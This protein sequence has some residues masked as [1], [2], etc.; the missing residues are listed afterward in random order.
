[1]AAAAASGINSSS[2]DN[3]GRDAVSPSSFRKT[4]N[5]VSNGFEDN[6]VVHR[7]SLVTCLSNSCL[8]TCSP[9]VVA[10]VR[11][12]LKRDFG[13][14]SRGKDQGRRESLPSSS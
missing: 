4:P 13:R 3:S 2:K 14:E 10:L 12:S 5:V 8:P 1:M 11:L 7:V 9:V 6:S